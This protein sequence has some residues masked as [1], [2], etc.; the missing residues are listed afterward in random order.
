M[1]LKKHAEKIET[2]EKYALQFEQFD[3]GDI[4]R[5]QEM[6][7]IILKISTCILLKRRGWSEIVSNIISK[8]CL[9]S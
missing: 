5:K 9:F 6:R 1:D 3:Y 7:K 4:F 2:I 8:T